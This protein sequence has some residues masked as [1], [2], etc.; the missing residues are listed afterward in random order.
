MTDKHILGMIFVYTLLLFF[1]SVSR[2]SAD[3][4]PPGEVSYF[5]LHQAENYLVGMPTAISPFHLSIAMSLFIFSRYAAFFLP[6][7]FFLGS[8]VFFY[9]TL[10]ERGATERL[11]LFIILFLLAS[12]SAVFASAMLT[13][14]GFV[15]FVLSISFFF[16]TRKYW[17]LS[18][19]FFAVAF[20]QSIFAPL[21]T[22]ILLGYLFYVGDR[23]PKAF[24]WG[25]II[26]FFLV[27]PSFSDNLPEGSFFIGI[28]DFGAPMGEGVFTLVLVILGLKFLWVKKYAHAEKYALFILS[29]LGWFLFG[30][31]V[32]L[33]V[34]FS[35]AYLSAYGF[36]GLLDSQWESRIVKQFT[37][38]VLL[39]GLLFSFLSY[40]ERLSH[41][42]PDAPL[43][44][45]MSWISQYTPQDSVVFSH[46]SRGFWIEYFGQRKAFAA[47]NNPKESDVNSIFYSQHMDKTLSLLNGRNS[48]YIWIDKPMKKEVWRAEEGLLLLF[49]NKNVFERV[50]NEKGI[51]LWKVHASR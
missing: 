17:W 31:D 6:I 33:F 5:H 13:Q 32:L 30:N 12:P 36:L 16:L 2:I 42:L 44:E 24:L 7:F 48:T 51:E 50:Y 23:Y 39:C 46:P 8:I 1:V 14:S 49:K 10:Q 11:S 47:S 4:P 40:G 19:F 18:F 15:L 9:L 29:V 37:I 27:R 41:E 45:G 34:H 21:I 26:L 38:L 3:L 43:L 20:W 25:I 28:T 35:F 22:V